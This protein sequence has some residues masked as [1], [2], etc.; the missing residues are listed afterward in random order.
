ME[1][2]LYTNKTINDRELLLYYVNRA[3]SGEVNVDFDIDRS[4]LYPYCVIHYVIKGSGHVIYGDKDYFIKQG[5]MF[6]LNAY[7]CHHYFTDRDNLLELDWLEFAGGDCVKLI[8][9]I[10]KNCGPIIRSPYSEKNN[11]YLLKIFNI[12]KSNRES[13]EFLIS[14]I[15][16]S[17]L[18]NL[19]YINKNNTINN[20]P[21]SSLVNISKVVYFIDNNINKNINIESLAKIS[22]YSPTYFAK[23]FYKVIG[24]TPMNYVLGKR[25]NKSKEYLSRTAISVEQ[26]S[27]MVGFCSSSHF[28]RSFKRFEGLTPAE[29][30]KQSLMFSS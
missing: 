19:L 7:E 16:Y 5:D 13:N 11:K 20:Y 22:C 15:I 27:E 4:N 30:R 12:I 2:F 25:I 17:M 10:L 24:N 28:I 1:N 8:T 26:I 6:L 3:G 14:K 18:I 23:L 29:Y 21:C 9:A